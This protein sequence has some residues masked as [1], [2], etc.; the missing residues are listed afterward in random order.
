MHKSLIAAGFHFLLI[1]Q[2]LL[3]N[4]ELVHVARITISSL[5]PDE[6]EGAPV[7]PGGAIRW[8][9]RRSAAIPIN[10]VIFY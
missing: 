5:G 1:P 6:I 4:T 3:L 9:V 8:D 7:F 2:D 10:A